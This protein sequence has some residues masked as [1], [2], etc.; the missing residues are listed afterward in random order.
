M[1]DIN[2]DLKTYLRLL[3]YIRPYWRLSLV[4]IL[5]MVVLAA[6]APALAA[7]MQPLLDGAFIEKDPVL[8]KW[9]PLL[10]ILLF[11][12][13]GIAAYIGEFSLRWVSHKLVMDIQSELF[14]RITSLPVPFYEKQ[15]PGKIISKFTYD[16]EQ[17][18]QAAI[19][20]ILTLFRDGLSIVGLLCWMF[21]IS[22]RLTLIILFTAP[23]I[24]IVIIVIKQR[25]RKMSR[26]SQES[27][28]NINHIINEAID[29]HKLVK[30]YS[31]EQQEAGR[32][33]QAVNQFRRYQM[34]FV[35]A[36]AASS[37][38]IQ[39]IT[40]TAFAVII[41]IATS[42]AVAGS[43][44]VGSFVS[45]FGAMGLILDPLKRVVRVNEQIQKG[46]AACESIFSI[47]DSPGET[48]TGSQEINANEISIS[49]DHVTFR[50]DGAEGEALHEL[51]FT[52]RPGQTV[53]LVG[54]SGSGKS[55]TAKLLPNFYDNY[56]GT[57]RINN[58]DIRD[59]SINSL[60]KNIAFVSQ[61]IMLF[62]DTVRNNIAYGELR[63]RSD[64]EIIEAARNAHALNFINKLPEGMHTVI[65]DKG[66]R[67]SGG[68][69]QRIAIARALLK[70]AP[71][72]ILDEATSLLDTESERQIQDA[73]HRL[74]QGKTCLII[75]HRLSTVKDADQILVLEQGQIVETGKHDELLAQQGVYAKLHQIVLD[76]NT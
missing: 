51:N 8:I 22:W 56:T 20:A 67:L 16:A 40:A 27:M 7:L 66:L 70:D 38:I 74:K 49:F 44:S 11:V 4:S 37:P 60:R 3:G 13:R 18:K 24:A 46:L 72:L 23:M 59:I 68:Q 69:R 57:I 75:A 19:N 15:T 12:L 52:I 50:Y 25:L 39:I 28:G 1:P 35:A 47:I 76:D 43:L 71:I 41:Y 32:F 45:F 6:T 64:E 61:E 2:S 17:I 9:M 34:K 29:G 53:A 55:T 63:D 21:Y 62:D 30:L 48:K 26:K 10:L 42:Q 54:A 65:G 5:S 36:A 73:L 33:K 58:I 14:L 31:A